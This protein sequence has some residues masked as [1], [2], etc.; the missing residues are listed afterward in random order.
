LLKEKREKEKRKEKK[1]REKKEKEKEREKSCC[2]RVA[3]AVFSLFY[4]HRKHIKS[5]QNNKKQL[6][7]TL[8]T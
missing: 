2:L 5:V 6:N 7:T 3:I 4:Y 1:K 8:H